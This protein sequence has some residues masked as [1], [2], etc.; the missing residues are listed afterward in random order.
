MNVSIDGR[1]TGRKG[2]IH[3]IR[4]V[5][6]EITMRMNLVGPMRLV[7]SFW[8]PDTSEFERNPGLGELLRFSQRAYPGTNPASRLQQLFAQSGT[9][10]LNN[11]LTQE[12]EQHAA[13]L[14]MRCASYAPDPSAIAAQL[15]KKA[16]MS[17]LAPDTLV[18]EYL[19][20]L[21]EISIDEVPNSAFEL[22]DHYRAVRMSE[23]VGDGLVPPPSG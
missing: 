20:N 12:L 6:S 23:I 7:I 16:D 21:Q 8:V 9:G 1:K 14:Q 11:R 17:N 22:P 19:L 13:I 4:A 18:M 2:I 3:G 15:Q 10:D 5:E